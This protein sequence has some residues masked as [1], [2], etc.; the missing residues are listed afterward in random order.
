MLRVNRVL[1]AIL[2]F[3]TPSPRLDTRAQGASADGKQH[4]ERAVECDGKRPDRRVTL[5]RCQPCLDLP[6]RRLQLGRVC[7]LDMLAI[8]S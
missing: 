8:D 6:E 5:W 7:G 1:V 4:K 2:G 3:G